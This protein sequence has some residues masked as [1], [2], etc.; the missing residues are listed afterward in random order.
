[1]ARRNIR[2]LLKG[3]PEIE[4]V[5]EAANGREALALIKP[6]CSPASARRAGKR[7]AGG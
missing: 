5:G 6:S 4:I 1:V 3:D 7:V 2:L